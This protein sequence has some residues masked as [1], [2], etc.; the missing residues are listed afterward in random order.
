MA[1][2][3]A[4][5]GS[6]VVKTNPPLRGGGLSTITSSIQDEVTVMPGDP[7]HQPELIQPTA[8]GEVSV[9]SNEPLDSA[10][11]HNP[12]MLRLPQGIHMRPVRRTNAYGVQVEDTKICVIMVGLPARGKSFIAQ[13]G[14]PPYI[15]RSRDFSG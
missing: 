10:Q 1:V 15:D 5:H 4:I 12:Q 11:R 13:K 8:V 14:K 9:Q 7:A 2:P 6:G 3:E